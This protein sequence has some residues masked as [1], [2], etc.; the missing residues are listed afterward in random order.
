MIRTLDR[1]MALGVAAVAALLL[2]PGKTLTVQSD[3]S[4]PGR[5][6]DVKAGEFFFQAPDT[7]PAGLTT[8]RL[9]QIGLVVERLRAGAKGRALVADKGDDTR[10]AHM[11]WVVRLDEGKTVADLHRAA[12][13]GERTTPWGKQSGRSRLCASPAYVQCD[14]R[15]GAGEL[16][17][18]VLHRLGPRGS[19][20]VPPAQWDG[21]CTDRQ[22][23]NRHEIIASAPGCHRSHHG[24]WHRQVLVANH[25]RSCGHSSGE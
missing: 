24:W 3:G 2:A 21:P 15:P 12:Q 16:R 18:S 5:V 1:A 7:I 19:H 8:F 9:Q 25:R 6:V 4:L 22:A 17:A 11:L 10:G 14:A 13:A 20:A 23:R